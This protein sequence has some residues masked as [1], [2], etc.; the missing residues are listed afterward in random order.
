MLSVRSNAQ[1]AAVK[2]LEEL[3]ATMGPFSS[4]DRILTFGKIE[5]GAARTYSCREE[6]IDA[7]VY[8]YDMGADKVPD[9]ID[10]DV[11]RLAFSD[12]KNEIE[13]RAQSGTY[14]NLQLLTEDV[15]SFPVEGRDEI[16]SLLAVYSYR[17]ADGT[18]A[19]GGPL[20]QSFLTVR[21]T[22]NHL[23][24]IRASFIVLEGSNAARLSGGFVR[25]VYSTLA[26]R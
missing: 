5:Y 13:S 15:A 3:P 22:N 23:V 1:P 26:L 14:Q 10:S 6:L 4:G 8:A 25:Q 18:G 12:S 7:T 16:K 9:G 19:A 21:G 2:I 24:K 20:Y 17:L 11:V